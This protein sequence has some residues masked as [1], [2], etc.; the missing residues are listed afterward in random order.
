MENRF[1]SICFFFEARSLSSGRA[2]VAAAKPLDRHSPGGRREAAAPA[3]RLG[4]LGAA[5]RVVR[6]GEV[7]V[8][9]GG[10]GGHQRRDH[11]VHVD[12]VRVGDARPLRREPVEPVLV[13]PPGGEGDVRDRQLLQDRV[14][15]YEVPRGRVLMR[16]ERR[17]LLSAQR[18]AEVLGERRG[19]EGAHQVRRE[20]LKRAV[21]ER[22]RA[23]RAGALARVAPSLRRDAAAAADL[24]QQ[25]LQRGPGAARSRAVVA[26]RAAH[27]VGHRG[28]GAPRA[29]RH[30]AV[31]VVRAPHS[32]DPRQ[33][34]LDAAQRRERVVVPLGHP[35]RLPPRLPAPRDGALPPGDRLFGDSVRQVVARRDGEKVAVIPHLLLQRRGVG[36]SN[37]SPPRP[38]DEDHAHAPAARLGDAQLLADP[39]AAVAV[40]R[41]RDDANQEPQPRRRRAHT[42]RRRDQA[43]G[44]RSRPYA[45]QV[46]ERRQWL[47]RASRRRA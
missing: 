28:E 47:L 31:V 19:G 3:P 46:P 40:Q 11:L 38:E 41:R 1:N 32:L 37:A 6:V 34:G 39:D 5:N 26:A 27:A 35:V 33:V 4:A 17:P 15:E 29:P 9:V 30:H 10:G 43:R 16:P 12:D 24:R 45:G 20:D 23:E 18:G 22:E 7:V 8:C 13:V 42:A 2:L 36:R 25:R 44:V 14:V 21:R